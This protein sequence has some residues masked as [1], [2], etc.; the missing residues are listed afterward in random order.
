MMRFL[1]LFT[2][3][4]FHGYHSESCK[5]FGFIIPTDTQQLFRNGK[6]ITKVSNGKLQLLFEAGQ[7]HTPLV[8]ITRK[9]LRMGLQLLNP[10]FSNFTNLDFDSNLFKP[11]YQNGINSSQLSAFSNIKIVG[12]RFNHLFKNTIRPLTVLL[13]DSAGHVLQT[14]TIIATQ[15]RSHISYDLNGQPAGIYD[16]EESDAE[17]TKAIAYYVDSELHYQGVF[18]VIEITIADSF[19]TQPPDFQIAFT[20]KQQPLKYYVVATKYSET[21]FNQLSIADTGF[22]E[23]ARPPIIFTPVLP[24]DFTPEEISPTLLQGSNPDARVVLF[25]SQTAI[26]RQDKARRRIQLNKNGDPLIPHLPQVGADKPKS[27]LIIQ[28]T[29]P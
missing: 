6:L 28:L 15:D 8:N 24:D 27:D 17:T 18:G 21:D 25:K 11:I 22:T 20:A 16:V 19:Y 29:K 23:D 4:I 2:I 9:T 1:T 14:D 12:Q 5:D 10:Y 26:A 7:T 3:T 13:K